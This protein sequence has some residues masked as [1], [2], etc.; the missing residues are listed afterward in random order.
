MQPTSIA[1]RMWGPLEGPGLTPDM[2]K[3][4]V[5][6]AQRCFGAPSPDATKVVNSPSNGNGGEGMK[7]SEKRTGMKSAKR[8][9]GRCVRRRLRNGRWLPAYVEVVPDP[10]LPLR[11][12]LQLER[13][14][15]GDHGAPLL[16]GLTCDAKSLGDGDLDGGVA[17][18]GIPKPR[19][20]VLEGGRL[21]HS[22]RNVTTVT[23]EMQ[24][25]LRDL[26]HGSPG[27]ALATPVSGPEPR[28]RNSEILSA[29]MDALPTFADRLRDAMESSGTTQADLAAALRISHVAVGKWM[30]GGIPNA[31]NMAAAARA[32]RVRADWL[33]A[34]H[35]PREPHRGHEEH[36]ID[37]AIDLLMELRGP[38][39]A[40]TQVIERLAALRA[41][42]ARARHK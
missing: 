30:K 17:R 15:V 2:W 25:K 14:K 3:A 12:A 6:A 1:G 19:L 39:L 37:E 5:K 27:T 22:T 26:R 21:E 28:L 36:A 34:G 13:R 38:L 32:L 16:D 31:D 11:D 9:S 4:V 33:R 18:R 7:D 20:E 10:K 24:P 23:S 29:P 40:L 41:P 35:L 8:G 42:P